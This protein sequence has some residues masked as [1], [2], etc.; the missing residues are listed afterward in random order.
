MNIS[1]NTIDQDRAVR[2]RKLRKV[3]TLGDSEVMGL[4]GVDFEI[5]RGSLTVLKG[6]S[7]SGKSTLLALM[8]GLDTPSSGTLI[9][10]GRNVAEMDGQALTSFRREQVGMV[11]QNFNLLPTLSVLENVMLPALLSEK[12]EEEVRPR[13]EELLGGL[14]LS[15]RLGHTPSRL[16]GGEMQRTAIARALINSPKIILADEPTG[17]LDSKNGALV[18]ELLK[19]LRDDLGITVITATH[20]DMADPV[21]DGMLHLRDGK[22]VEA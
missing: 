11:F 7:G 20:S 18:V 10:A 8:A 17:N 12:A 9:V 15:S 13:A 19:G 5:A 2:A 22:L 3:Y 14:G 4:D 21:A 16:S 6:A 1:H